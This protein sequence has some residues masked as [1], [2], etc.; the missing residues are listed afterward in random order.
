MNARQGF[1]P[2]LIRRPAAIVSLSVIVIATLACAFAG[3]ISPYDPIAADFGDV[4]SLPTAAHPLGTDALGRD[5]LSRLLWGGRVTLTSAAIAVIV[6]L[7]IGIVLGL[8]AGYSGKVVDR[9][10]MGYVDTMQ[11]FPSLII[12][13]VVLAVF[14]NNLTAAMIALGVI[15]TSPVTKVVRAASLTVRNE[16]YVEAARVSG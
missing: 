10:I 12:L 2:R 5:L 4:L 9:L 3:V 15:L 16:L 8:L 13:L 7:A 6:A 1:V 11:S 14:T